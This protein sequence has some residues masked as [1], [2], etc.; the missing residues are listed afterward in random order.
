MTIPNR[1]PLRR[2]HRPPATPV[3]FGASR[4]PRPTGGQEVTRAVD[5]VRWVF[6][7]ARKCDGGGGRQERTRQRKTNG[8][9]SKIHPT[10]TVERR[11]HHVEPQPTKQFKNPN[12]TDT[13]KTSHRSGL[14]KSGCS[15]YTLWCD[16]TLTFCRRTC[17]IVAVRTGAALSIAYRRR[18]GHSCDELPRA[19]S[20]HGTDVSRPLPR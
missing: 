8:L 17:P 12:M 15:Y 13:S 11:V 14:K 4:Q 9:T 20:E 1:V 18:R 7:I 3:L 16:M 2:Y 5:D 10:Q 19:R 6:V